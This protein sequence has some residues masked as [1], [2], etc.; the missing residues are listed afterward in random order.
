MSHCLSLQPEDNKTMK[1]GGNLHD[2]EKQ[3]MLL[4]QGRGMRQGFRER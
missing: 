3:G 2:P 4:K 1:E